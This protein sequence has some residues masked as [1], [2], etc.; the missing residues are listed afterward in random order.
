MNEIFNGMC[1]DIVLGVT[2]FE[3]VVGNDGLQAV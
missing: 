3:A 2:V 1:G